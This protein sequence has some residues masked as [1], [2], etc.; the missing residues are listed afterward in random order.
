VGLSWASCAALADR[1]RALATFTTREGELT[2]GAARTFRRLTPT[3]YRDI[4]IFDSRDIPTSGA[5]MGKDERSFMESNRCNCTALRKA[6][7]RMS[8]FY[9]STLAPSGLRSTQFAMLAELDRR[10]DTPPTIRELSEAL[11]MDQS[12]IGQNLRP[13]GR[14]GLISLVQDESDRRSRRVKIT[15]AGRSR[16]ADAR[17]LW[18]VA[19]QTFEDGFGKRAAAELRSVLANIARGQSLAVEGDLPPS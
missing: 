10:A 15:K 7:R 2:V 14:E 9:D 8:Q 12:T 1:L 19:Q 3:K 18:S 6:S 17:P 16:L 13:L 5:R 11:V 4:L